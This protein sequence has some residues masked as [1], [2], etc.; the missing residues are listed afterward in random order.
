MWSGKIIQLGQAT[1][2]W[3]AYRVNGIS[4]KARNLMFQ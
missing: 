3:L 2:K 1:A 4:K